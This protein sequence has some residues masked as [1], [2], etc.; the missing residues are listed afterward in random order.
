MA[1]KVTMGCDR[2]HFLLLLFAS[3]VEQHAVTMSPCPSCDRPHMS[4]LSIWQ[5]AP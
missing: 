2:S 3:S 5:M 1:E 4:T